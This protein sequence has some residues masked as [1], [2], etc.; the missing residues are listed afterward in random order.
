MRTVH[1]LALLAFRMGGRKSG[2]LPPMAPLNVRTDPGIHRSFKSYL[3]STL[4]ALGYLEV[5]EFL[6]HSPSLM[7]GYLGD[8]GASREAL[9]SFGWYH[10]GDIGYIDEYFNMFITDRLKEV[11]KVKGQVGFHRSQVSLI[12]MTVFHNSFQVAPA[13]LDSLVPL[14]L[15][16][17]Q[18]QSTTSG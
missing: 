1:T 14:L 15:T 17:T 6:V 9:D 12:L 3:Y 13:E 8:A 5:G 18:R 11:L 10:T 4:S 16:L 2:L 7:S